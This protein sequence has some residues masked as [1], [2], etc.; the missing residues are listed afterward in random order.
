MFLYHAISKLY[1]YIQKKLCIV[2]YLSDSRAVL[3]ARYENMINLTTRSDAKIKQTDLTT[4]NP[5]VDIF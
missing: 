1:I 5:W 3:F 4:N 2:V